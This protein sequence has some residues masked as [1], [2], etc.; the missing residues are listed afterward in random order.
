MRY[1]RQL[2]DEPEKIYINL[3][4]KF[5]ESL[6]MASQITHPEIRYHKAFISTF[7]ELRTQAHEIFSCFS[8]H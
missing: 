4:A 6:H 5:N 8:E 1:I 3:S 2:F 7:R